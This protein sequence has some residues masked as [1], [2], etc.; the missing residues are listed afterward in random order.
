MAF[1]LISH[2]AVVFDAFVLIDLSVSLLRYLV[3]F[4]VAFL[5][6]QKSV[7]RF[8][9]LWAVFFVYLL[10]ATFIGH[11]KVA[12]VIGPSIDIMI[13]L[14]MFHVYKKNIQT[15][16]KATTA[17]LSFYVYLNMLLLILFPDGL[18]TDPISGNGYY[19]LGGNY[20]GIGA[21]VVCALTTNM[22]IC[23]DNRRAKVNIIC[24]L[25]ASLFSV[26]FVRSMTSTVSII[27][28]VLLWLLA[29]IK[30]HRVLVIAFVIFYVV[31][32]LFVVFL[33]SDIS[34]LTAIV[35][36][37][38]NV[39]HKDTTFTR[40]SLLWENSADLIAK[41][42]WI[43]YGYQDKVW[44]EQMLDGPGAHNFVYTVLLYGGYP[45]LLMFVGLVV[46]AVKRC[47]SQFNEWTLSRLL[48]GVC[49]FFFMMIFEYYSF[50]LIA[51]LLILTYYYPALC[52]KVKE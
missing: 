35:D 36:F 2:A 44:N 52:P 28:L 27:M 31:V 46:L 25:A 20:N 26:L 34:N 23:K 11:G 30:K 48:L 43:G 42:P 40:R 21:R 29:G 39:L 9:I 22:L 51:Y 7:S 17:V 38:E 45:L 24:L 6:L 50:F 15:V 33:L 3:F 10:L 4:F 41:S 13:L 47:A 1:I 49:V 5:Y 14:M 37:M 19:L 16:L 18:W 12:M 8:E 32:Q